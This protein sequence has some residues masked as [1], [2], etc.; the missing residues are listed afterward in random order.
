MATDQQSNLT[1]AGGLWLKKSKRNVSYMSGKTLVAIPE[2][3]KVLIFKNTYKEAGDDK[4]D[5]TL[6]FEVEELTQ[7]ATAVE[8]APGD[9]PF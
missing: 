9:I 7:T 2:G 8:S 3:A 5:Y 1:K 6:Q 4:P